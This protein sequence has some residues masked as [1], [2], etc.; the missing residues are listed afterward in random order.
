MNGILDFVTGGGQYADPNAMHPVYGVPQSDVRQ[1]LLNSLM[2]AGASLL[3]AGQPIAP[4]QRAQLLGQAGA[5]FS[6]IG[7]DVYNAA[8]RRL[9]QQQFETRRAQAASDR[10]LL[11]AAQNPV[12]FRARYGFDP[13]GLDAPTIRSIMARQ[14]EEVALNPE[15]PETR[16]L[17][18]E[19][20]RRAQSPEALDLQR[21]K[22]EADVSRA[23]AEGRLSQAQADEISR[24]AQMQRE[25]A[26]RLQAA[27]GAVPGTAPAAPGAAPAAMG[28]RQFA[29]PP[30]MRDTMLAAGVKPSEIEKQAANFALNQRVVV[31][32]AADSQFRQQLQVAPDI[33]LSIT[34]DAA[35]N[36]V[37]WKAGEPSDKPPAGYRWAVRPQEGT[38][39]RLET[40]PGGPAEK[41]EAEVGGRVGLAQAF[42]GYLPEIRKAID[43]NVLTSA[44]GRAQM[45]TGIGSAAA[46]SI[47]RRVDLGKE[48]LL[49]GLT[50][51]GMSEAEAAQ[52]AQRFSPQATDSAETIAD[53]VNMLEYSLKNVQEVIARARGGNI[54]PTGAAPTFAPSAPAA[55]GDDARIMSFIQRATAAELLQMDPSSLTDAQ[56]RAYVARLEAVRA[57]GR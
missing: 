47:L 33:P 25:A 10:Q 53:K 51:A 19:Q 55:A 6:G 12:D 38:P 35:G 28:A 34:L 3:A 46:A 44:S 20:L 9:M 4:A 22:L 27:P 16:R 43:D 11:E 50:G 29:M 37:D 15:A 49:R 45:A 39:G 5:A 54:G 48:A 31:P 41:I 18:L 30:Q 40:I 56:K 32:V 36:V 52:Y 8:Q 7:T 14:R 13:S 24:S 1:A 42:Y 2:G 26:A 57:G 21:R 23:V 17:Q